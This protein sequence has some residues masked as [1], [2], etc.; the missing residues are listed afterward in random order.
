[1]ITEQV[2]NLSKHIEK[3]LGVP[4]MSRL[5][6]ALPWTEYPLYFQ[7]LECS[8]IINTVYQLCN[9]NALLC[10]DQTLWHHSSRY[11]IPRSLDTLDM[12]EVFSPRNP[13]GGYFIAIQSYLQIPFETINA[14]VS[15]Y[16]VFNQPFDMTY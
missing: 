11:R 15:P 3:R 8:G 4:W 12:D 13:L 5:A 2:R 10:F 9:R 14:A 6:N 7:F 16:L 1:M